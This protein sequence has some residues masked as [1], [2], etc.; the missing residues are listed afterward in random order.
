[1]KVTNELLVA[2]W[3]KRA[4]NSKQKLV[5]G[6]LD[7]LLFSLLKHVKVC[8]AEDG[9][10]FLSIFCFVPSVNKASW[11]NIRL[12]KANISHQAYKEQV[13]KHTLS[14]LV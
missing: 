4:T 14:V 8:L 5:S 9:S 11:H 1:M 7:R 13:Q 6:D 2:Q 3:F 12:K 10:H